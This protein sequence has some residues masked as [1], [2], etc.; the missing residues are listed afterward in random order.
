[1]GIKLFAFVRRAPG[2]SVS[3]FH[4]YWR[5]EHAAHIAGTPALRRHVRRYELNHRLDEDYAREPHAAEMT[6]GDHDGVAVMWFDPAAAMD[7]FTAE[8]GLAAWAAAD[9]PRFR[10]PEMPSVVT[11]D[12]TVIVD[13]SRR[14]QASAKLVCIL[15]RNAALDLDTFHTHWLHNHGGLFQN[16]PE[17]RA[18]LW[19]YHQN[20]GIGGPDADYDGVTEQWFEDLPHWIESL[21]VPAHHTTVEPDVAYLLDP[22]SVRFVIAGRPTVV[23]DG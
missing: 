22:T 4:E 8:P 3:D 20:H 16:I 15:R 1:M 11:D 14:D 21:G 5:T 18:P 2:M 17:L 23:I 13:T 7:A 9:A 10:A 12:A 19:G 6:S